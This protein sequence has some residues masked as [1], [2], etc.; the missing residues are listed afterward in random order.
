MNATREMKI[1]VLVKALLKDKPKYKAYEI[2]KLFEQA[3]WILEKD[4]KQLIYNL[5]KNR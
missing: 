1:N 5:V 2:V 3:K 4:E